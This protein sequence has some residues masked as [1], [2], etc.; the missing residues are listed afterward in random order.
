MI[1]HRKEFEINE[2]ILKMKINLE[3]MQIMP[4]DKQNK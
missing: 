4:S 2:Y 3:G 1:A